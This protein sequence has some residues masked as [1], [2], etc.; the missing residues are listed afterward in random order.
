MK[1]WHQDSRHS[2]KEWKKWISWHNR[3]ESNEEM[4]H[5]SKGRFRKKKPFDCGNSKCF[6]CHSDR[7]PK[8]DENYQEWVSRKKLQ[9]GLEELDE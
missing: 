8:R 2:F 1:R 4:F 9:E 7:Y 3:Y 5:V 6:Q